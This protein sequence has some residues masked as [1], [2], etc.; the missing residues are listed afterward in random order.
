MRRRISWLVAA[1]TSAVVLAFVIPLCLMVRT[2]AVDRAA[3]AG[4]E[5]ARS[6]AILVSGLHADPSLDQLVAQTDSRSAARTSVVA[7]DGRVLGSA[8]DDLREDLEFSSAADGQAF[9]HTDAD[10]MEIFVPVVTKEGTW[11]VH[12]TVSRSLMRA[13]VYRAWASIGL[14]GLLLLVAAVVIADRLGRR[15]ST[16]V[17][18]LAGVAQRLHEGDLD[19]RA[20]PQG[21]EETVELADTL[22]RLA[23]RI[24]ELLVA[25]R[26]AVGDL[27]HRLRTPVTAL[28]LDSEGVSDPDVRP[29]LEQHI[30]QLQRT[31]DA[32]VT[33]ARR[34]LRS[35][36]ASTC[37]ATTVLTDRVAFW[38]ALAEDQG[39]P[40]DVRLRRESAR[41]A[42]DAAD[43]IDVLDVLVDNVFAHTPETTP[44]RVTATRTDAGDVVLE[45]ADAGPGL[46]HPEDP[47][48]ARPGRTG[49][50]LQIVRRTV[51]AVG[52]HLEIDDADPGLRVTVRLPAAVPSHPP[53]GGLRATSTEP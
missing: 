15:V 30:E 49:L 41:V 32:I 17:V 35:T 10:G 40:F 44:F 33:D 45:V 21:P 7:P 18:Q 6:V 28:R 5:E 46:G 43:L 19:A 23:E 26:A 16:P 20:V 53:P 36:L 22:N 31:V 51:A 52:G 50:G 2:L 48:T 39:R 34:P 4:N 47:S 24:V 38:S 8:H 29:R 12:T 13:G 14:L 37:D 25:E 9:T 42:L 1:T 3:A 27:S 11:V